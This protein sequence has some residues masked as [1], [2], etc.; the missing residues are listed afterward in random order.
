[1]KPL[2]RVVCVAA[3]AACTQPQHPAN[4]RVAHAG[5]YHVQQ[6]ATVCGAGPTVHGI[7]VSYYQ[8][9]IDW[10]AVAAAG[11]KFAIVRHSDGY[12]HDPKFQQN[13]EGVRAAGM[14]R[15]VYQWFEPNQDPVR[16]ADELVAA[17]GVLGPGDLPVMADVEEPGP[18][19]PSPAVYAARLRVWV[20]RVRAGTG[21]DPMIYTGHYYWPQYL[22]TTEFSDLPLVHAQY[23]SRPCPNIPDA[24]AN[25][26]IWQY[27]S[28][29]S[30]P[31]IVG[32]V[33]M[34][35]FNGTEAQ[36]QELAGAS[37]DPECA[38]P[39]YGG[40]AGTV[41]TRCDHGQVA[42]GDCGAFGA[43]CSVEGGAPHCVHPYCIIH[44][45]GENATWCDGTVIKT[46]AGGQY[47]EGDCGAFGVVCSETGGTAHCIF[48][49]CA[50]HGENSSWCEGAVINTCDNGLWTSGNCGAYGAAC[51][52]L[53]GTA[54]CV[55]PYCDG[56]GENSA[57][58]TGDIIK[59]CR[60][61]A[62]EEG[63][64]AYYGASCSELG[65]TGHCV[66]PYCNG[67]GENATWC[68]ATTAKS[69]ALGVYAEVNC[70]DTATTCADGVGCVGTPPP[71]DAGM[72]VADAAVAPDSA[73]ATDA[74]ATNVD[75]STPADASRPG[76]DA[77]PRDAAVAD[78]GGRDAGAV[79]TADAGGNVTP[80]PPTE[81]EPDGPGIGPFHCQSTPAHVWL[82]SIP[83][84]LLLL[85]RRPGRIRR[86][87]Q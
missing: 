57:W 16:Q 19:V 44:G 4:G 34:N 62:Y 65:G 55:H 82:G 66:H 36:L 31:G 14:I 86:K 15:G 35:R 17:V 56:H 22:A 23:T 3:V 80:Q 32:N 69:C 9:N 73:V 27:S 21:R 51:S 30:V 83:I 60:G 85:H 84:A 5:D 43:G 61:G 68:D 50:A 8:G 67:H 7:D 18:N 10:N 59:T 46:C 52:D 72:A 77:G 26:T 28:T 33:D 29:G 37:M 78:A 63:D 42:S 54:H 45:A 75:A 24:W 74:G 1:M 49:Q 71:V 12:F 20:D 47:S 76:A 58:C 6:A 25:W 53:G 2:G 64:C 39:N 40:C 38:N 79:N 81:P 48:P 41:I 70:A 11:H 13:W 87:T